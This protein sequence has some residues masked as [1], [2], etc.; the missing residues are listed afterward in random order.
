[1]G[2]IAKRPIANAVW[3]VARREG[4][5]GNVTGYGAEYFKR[6]LEMVDLGDIAGEPDNAV[7]TSLG[8]TF[9]HPEVNVAIVGTAN[10]AHMASNIEMVNA[11]VDI[12]GSVV[13]ELH[14]R[15]E[16]VGSG[17]EQRG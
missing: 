14:R 1:M 10:D 7:Q 13:G 8:F 17:W 9:A 16:Q 6:A 4:H 15:F 5:A 11:G 12:P 2:V 3:L